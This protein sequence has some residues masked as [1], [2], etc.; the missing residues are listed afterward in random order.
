M[1]ILRRSRGWMGSL[2]G[3]GDRLLTAARIRFW[4][5]YNLWLSIRS[6][7]YGWM[8]NLKCTKHGISNLPES[9]CQFE[10]TVGW[11]RLDPP[12]A[13]GLICIKPHLQ[14]FSN[15]LET[16]LGLVA[17]LILRFLFA[18]HLNFSS[19]AGFSNWWHRD[20]AGWGQVANKG[21]WVNNMLLQGWW[22]Q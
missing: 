15:W 7:R 14:S 10:T 16:L 11:G 13:T 6:T 20:M 2:D 8:K 5:L 19:W 18:S 12:Q 22:S 4:V 9:Q 21:I 3:G 17:Y 1:V